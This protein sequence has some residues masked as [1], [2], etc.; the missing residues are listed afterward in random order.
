[1]VASLAAPTRLGHVQ[2]ALNATTTRL[3]IVHT[4]GIH[5]QALRLEPF[6][7]I[8]ALAMKAL[9]EDQAFGSLVC[10]SQVFAGHLDVQNAGTQQILAS[11]LIVKLRTWQKYLGLSSYEQQLHLDVIRFQH[12]AAF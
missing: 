8:S 6:H 1:M 4:A 12:L 9:M 5:F 2:I 11:A 10:P 3:A 7:S